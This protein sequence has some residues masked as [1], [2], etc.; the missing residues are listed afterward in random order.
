MSPTEVNEMMH[1]LMYLQPKTSSD[2]DNFS[3]R[4]MKLIGEKITLPITILINNSIGEGIVSDE[5]KIEKVITAYKSKAT[6]EYF[7]YIPISLLPS[8]Y[9][10]LGK[11]TEGH[12]ILY[13]KAIC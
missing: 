7:N 4:L 9:K 10:I 13:R 11:A 1:I 2:Y 6:D 8:I 12:M 5:I 3:P